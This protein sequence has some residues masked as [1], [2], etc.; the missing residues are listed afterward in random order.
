MKLPV[1]PPSTNTMPLVR[2]SPC[3]KVASNL[4]RSESVQAGSADTCRRRATG[5]SG[6]G[7]RDWESC[8]LGEASWGAVVASGSG[9]GSGSAEEAAESGSGSGSAEEAAGSGSG[10]GSAEEVAESGSGS[11]T[12]IW[13]GE[14]GTGE[15][16]G[17]QHRAEKRLL[18]SV[19]WVA[20]LLRPGLELRPAKAREASTGLGLSPPVSHCRA[21]WGTA[22]R[23]GRAPCSRN[24]GPGCAGAA[25]PDR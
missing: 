3:L 6:G 20:V 15:F 9:S 7:R 12:C 25:C 14:S 11:G 22:G 16:S 4:R 8:F 18:R 21:C 19:F 5:V 2:V 10:S 17:E 24:T 23:C 1:E 13:S